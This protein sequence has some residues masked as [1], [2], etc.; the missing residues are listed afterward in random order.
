MKKLFFIL[1][2]FLAINANAFAYWP[3]IFSV[4]VFLNQY[5]A[6]ARVHNTSYYPVACYGQVI[7]LSSSGVVLNTYV[8]GVV[9]NP[10]VSLDIYVRANS[11]YDPMIDARA[12]IQCF[13]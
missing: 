13:N 1:C 10:G 9:I 7:G 8:N 6:V 12:D 2:A 4:N 11:V 3:G 5:N